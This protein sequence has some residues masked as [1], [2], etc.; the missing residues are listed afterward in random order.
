MIRVHEEY[1]IDVDQ[2]NYTAQFDTHKTRYDKKM[3]KEVPVYKL[4]G[5]YNTLGGA[6]TGIHKDM[7]RQALSNRDHNLVSAIDAVKQERIKFTELMNKVLK[8]VV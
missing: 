3:D 7:V 8:E 6:L 4:V 5:Y 1:V 2:Y